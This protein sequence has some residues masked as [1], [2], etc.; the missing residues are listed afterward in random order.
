MGID[1]LSDGDLGIT[2]I[3]AQFEGNAPLWFYVLKEAELLGNEKLGPM[4]GRIVAEVLLGLLKGDP[5]SYINVEPNW[6]PT[7]SSAA[8]FKMADLIAFVG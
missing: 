1:P 4:G 6:K 5:S 2:G 7:L 8:D 3:D